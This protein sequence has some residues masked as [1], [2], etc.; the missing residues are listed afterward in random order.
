MVAISMNL[1][2]PLLLNKC[3]ISTRQSGSIGPGY[4]PCEYYNNGDVLFC[5]P[6]C[7]GY[8][9]GRFI[10]MAGVKECKLSTGNAN[11]WWG[12]TSD[13]YQRGQVPK[14]GA[15][16]CWDTNGKYGHVAV[17]EEVYNDLSVLI[18]ESRFVEGAK[19][20][21]A[22]KK[23]WNAQIIPTS[24]NYST[25]YA[26]FR[27]FIYNPYLNTAEESPYI[28]TVNRNQ[29]VPDLFTLRNYNVSAVIVEATTYYDAITHNEVKNK[30]NSKL[31]ECISALIKGEIPY[32]VFFNFRSRT[33][34]DVSAELR[35]LFDAIKSY[36]IGVGIWARLH[37]YANNS[38]DLND[39]IINECRDM[40]IKAGYQGEI[41]LYFD[42]DQLNYFNVSKHVSDWVLWVDD[43]VSDTV[44][45]NTILR[46]NQVPADFYKV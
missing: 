9:W 36:D 26:K 19:Y 7:V 18:S 8:A 21:P 28:I 42:R 6:N 34:S 11:Q 20:D 15:I 2:A 25:I 37:L 39:R 24:A 43:P 5:L 32:G 16:M 45:M 27:G 38:R 33:V 14:V 23:H 1:S 29:T 12:N 3:Y 13:G 35:C 17:V 44:A 22:D 31:S 40:L 41:G 30:V 46:S 10:E 4:N